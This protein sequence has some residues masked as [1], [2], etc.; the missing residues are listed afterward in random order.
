MTDKAETEAWLS[1]M[2]GRL[3]RA[4]AFLLHR[5]LEPE[6]DRE[7]RLARAETMAEEDLLPG[8]DP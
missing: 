3:G 4:K 1:R 8:V 2:E 5:G 7:A 6:P